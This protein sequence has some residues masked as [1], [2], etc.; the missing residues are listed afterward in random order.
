MY[1][2]DIEHDRRLAEKR[3]GNSRNF[4]KLRDATVSLSKTE[5]SV[6]HSNASTATPKGLSD[7]AFEL[8]VEGNLRTEVKG[9]KG[10]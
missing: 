6:K 2:L 4:R 3:L 1:A 10:H 5:T 7:A 9:P 8:R